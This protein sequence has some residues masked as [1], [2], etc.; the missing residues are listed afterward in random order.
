MRRIIFWLVGT[1]VT[2]GLIGA[3]FLYY[4]WSNVEITDYPIPPRANATPEYEIKPSTVVTSL[5]VPIEEVRRGLERD[6]PRTLVEIDQRVEECIPRET[7][8]VFGA[9]LFKTPRVGCDL[10]GEVRRGSIVLE[11]SGRTLSATMPVTAEIEVR[12]I[13]DVIKRETATAAAIIEVRA[14]LGVSG[15]WQLRPDI[16]IGYRWFEEPQIVFVGQRIKLTKFADPEFA[17]VLRSVE[18]ELETQ[19][20]QVDIRT[21]VAS[22]W[23]SG[24]DTISVNRENPPVWLRST[25]KQA[26][27][28]SLRIAGNQ[29]TTNLMLQSDLEVFVGDEPE[30]PA[31]TGLGPNIGILRG[32]GFEVTVPVLADYTE[33]EPVILRA[34][35]RLAERGIRVEELG[36]LE[37]DFEAVTLYATENG[38]LAV[39]VEAEAAPV[40]NITGRIWG[41]SLGKVW[42]TADPVTE[43]GSEVVSVTNLEIFGDMDNNVGDLLVRVIQSP[44]VKAEI[45]RELVEDFKSEYVE[46]I[47]KAREGIRS[48]RVGG[49]DLSFRIDTVEHGEVIATSEGL[50]MAVSANGG[51]TT[52]IR[53]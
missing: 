26:G 46:V 36:E 28:G 34:L 14:T 44:D 18:Q 32:R 30:K 22:A 40:G 38:R 13:G 33:I 53:R 5:S 52:R 49:F 20:R 10:A 35:K 43:P 48:V 39:G 1:I 16:R 21:Q 25:P 11:G 19:I 17:K 8:R 6:L 29:V 9:R 27:I 7:V 51:V 12:N 42:L 3:G 15:N 50:F 47:G 24:F 45:E 37:V 23:R 31:A 4:V 41:R 2:L